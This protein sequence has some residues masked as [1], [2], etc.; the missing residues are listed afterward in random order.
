MPKVKCPYANCSWSLDNARRGSEA[1]VV[2]T[3]I[4]HE[5][6]GEPIPEGANR[7]NAYGNKKS[8]MEGWRGSD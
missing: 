4:A 3:H 5:H 8:R 7:A 2:G 6:R 1:D